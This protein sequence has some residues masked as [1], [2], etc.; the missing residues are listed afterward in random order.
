MLL[1][2]RRM[3]STRPIVGLALLVLGPP[4]CAG[5]E[6]ATDGTST[7][8]TTTSTTTGTPT[9]TEASTSSTSGY[10]P[11]GE[12]CEESAECEVDA[13]CCVGCPSTGFP[14]NWT[15]DDGTCVHGGCGSDAECDGLHQDFLCYGVGGAS[16]CV[17]PCTTHSQCASLHKMP[18]TCCT[19]V[20][21][22]GNFCQEH[23][24]SPECPS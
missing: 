13:D 6:V 3:K 10:V 8:T 12:V 4:A 2:R 15:C 5:D 22:Q 16:V 20:G 14:Y 7:S 11:D 21:T 23:S 19:G 9:T 24:T 1:H 18:G 17:A